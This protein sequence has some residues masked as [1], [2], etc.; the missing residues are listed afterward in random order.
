MRSPSAASGMDNDRVIVRHN[1]VSVAAVDAGG[2]ADDAKPRSVAVER[3]R[4]AACHR[5]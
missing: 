5:S 2:T 1:S 4:R 3:S